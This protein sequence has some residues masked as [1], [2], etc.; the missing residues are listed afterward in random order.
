MANSLISQ[1]RKALDD[2]LQYGGDVNE[3]AVRKAFGDL[4]NSMAEQHGHKVVDELA[5]GTKLGTTVYPDAT[6]K[7]FFRQD[8]GYWEANQKS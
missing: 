1:Y 5:Y 2:L 7:D 4:L 6:V 8:W 3:G